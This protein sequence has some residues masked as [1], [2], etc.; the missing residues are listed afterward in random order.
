[1]PTQLCNKTT[2][3]GIIIVELLELYLL[4]CSV[5]V[6]EEVLGSQEQDVIARKNIEPADDV[7]VVEAETNTGTFAGN[8]RGIANTWGEGG[9]ERERE[10][11]GERG[12][13]KERGG[14]G[15]GRGKR[16]KINMHI[17]PSLYTSDII[18]Y[19]MPDKCIN[20]STTVFTPPPHNYYASLFL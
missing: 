5:G 15:G 8:L 10:R 11:E 13:E 14:E 17:V 4:H 7:K 1:M 6:G 19:L 12:R 9:R 16:L 18:L 20:T 2:F 3:S